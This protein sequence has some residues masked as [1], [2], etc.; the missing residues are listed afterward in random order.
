MIVYTVSY[1]ICTLF[2]KNDR[3]RS[4]FDFSLVWNTVTGACIAISRLLGLAVK[5]NV[6]M[7]LPLELL[8]ADNMMVLFI[9]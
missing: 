6:V 9:R 1:F 2:T 5:S 3:S 4:R 7:P 8:Y